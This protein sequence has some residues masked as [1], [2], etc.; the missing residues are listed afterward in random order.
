MEIEISKEAKTNRDAYQAVQAQMELDHFGKCVLMHNGEI[1]GIY[2]T[3]SDAY[4]V[5]CEK[6]GLGE[7]TTEL[8]GQK[9]MHLGIFTLCLPQ[10]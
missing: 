8:V 10:K 2:D 5:G 6:F 9:P 3:S 4:A 1:V 7:F